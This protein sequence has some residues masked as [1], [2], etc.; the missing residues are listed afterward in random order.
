MTLTQTI[1]SKSRGQAI[2][3]KVISGNMP[4]L[5]AAA[6]VAL[7][8]LGWLDNAQ[9]EILKPW[10]VQVLRNARGNPVGEIR[11]S[12]KLQMA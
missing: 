1:A 4:A 9:R 12:L 6:V 8:Q 2:A 10:G 11:A 7:D 3:I 5:Y